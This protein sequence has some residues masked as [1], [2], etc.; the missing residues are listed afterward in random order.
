MILP[1]GRVYCAASSSANNGGGV[2]MLLVPLLALFTSF[3]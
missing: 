3:T 2:I 1:S